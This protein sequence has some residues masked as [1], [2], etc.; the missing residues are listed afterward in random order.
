DRPRLDD[1]RR[2]LHCLR[3]PPLAR[4]GRR[5]RDPP[6]ARRGRRRR[7]P[8]L[9][10]RL[11]TQLRQLR[12]PRLRHAALAAHEDLEPLL[13]LLE[14]AVAVLERRPPPLVLPERLAER[15]RAA[16]ELADDRVEALER[17]LEGLQVDFFSRHRSPPP[18]P[19]PPARA[20]SAA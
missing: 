8:R 4:R 14:D 6:L 13:R 15:E 12:R 17:R 5:G 9:P 1:D 19:P 10:P 2:G 11:A 20:A 16:L 7:D 18:T 3:D